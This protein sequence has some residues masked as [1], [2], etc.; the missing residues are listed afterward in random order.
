[1]E[2][3]RVELEKEQ[4]TLLMTLAM[5]ALDAEAARPVL[6]DRFA[7]G[8]LDRIDAPIPPAWSLRG[9][10]PIVVSRA[11]AID[12]YALRFLAAHPRAV[13]LHLGCGLDSRVLRL[14]PG[15]EVMWVDVDQAPVIELRRR[16]YPAPDGVRMIGASVTESGWWSEVPADRPVLAI[17]EGLLMYLAPDGVSAVADRLLELPAPQG[18][19]IADTASGWVRQASSLHP[20]MRRAGTGFRSSTG[21]LGAAMRRPG[22]TLV[23]ERSLVTL[24]ERDQSGLTAAFLGL[25][26][27]IPAGRDSM[28]LQTWDWARF[29]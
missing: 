12:E 4:R 2:R 10:L 14:S 3:E 17:A 29:R 19:L 11:K 25:V 16:L 1:M 15:P 9:N 5:H 23:D 22:V 21:D 24:A 26:G 18:S 27:R 8:V 20:D 7:Q 13:V 28:V 6:G